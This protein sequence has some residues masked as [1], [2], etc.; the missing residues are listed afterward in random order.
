LEPGDFLIMVSDGVM[1]ALPHRRGEEVM[2]ELILKQETKNAQEMAGSLLTQVLMYRK[3]QAADD[4]T[5]LVGGFW[6]RKK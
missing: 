5:I 6:K 1:D 3:C 2:Q 4:M